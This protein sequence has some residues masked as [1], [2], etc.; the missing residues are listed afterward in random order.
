M[1]LSGMNVFPLVK[2]DQF[3]NGYFIDK[4]GNVY[5]NKVS[6][7]TLTKLTG[8]S[9]PSGRY[10]TLNKR[11]YRAD[12]LIARA[13]QHPMFAQEVYPAAVAVAVQLATTA[14]AAVTPANKSKSAA[15]LVAAKGFVLATVGPSDKLVFGTDP[16]FQLD[17]PTATTEAERIANLKP[18]TRIV[19]LQAVRSVV[20]GGTKWE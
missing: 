4:D 10:Y 9:T 7:R 12:S 14:P 5:S 13:K 18:G 20:A 3:M 19:V 11:T 1:Q 15:K 16:M 8:S 6:M 2:M 17:L